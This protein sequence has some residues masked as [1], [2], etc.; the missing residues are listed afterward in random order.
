MDAEVERA[1]TGDPNFLCDVIPAGGGRQGDYSC[2]LLRV[3]I[4]RVG[5][6]V[7]RSE[8]LVADLRLSCSI[9]PRFASVSA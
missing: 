5:Q 3:R 6:A 9:L 7:L 8:I 4:S 2:G 1:L